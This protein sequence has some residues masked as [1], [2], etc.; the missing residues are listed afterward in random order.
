METSSKEW[1]IN[2]FE[3]AMESFVPS[4]LPEI[5]EDLKIEPDHYSDWSDTLY[6]RVSIKM[7][8]EISQPFIRQREVF[9]KKICL[10]LKHQ[11]LVYLN[12][13]VGIAKMQLDE[14]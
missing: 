11:F 8:K 5:F 1:S 12:T 13:N 6:I 4:I 9:S 14:L 3:R 7:K 10:F 2:S